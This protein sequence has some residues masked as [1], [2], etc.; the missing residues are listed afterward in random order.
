MLTDEIDIYI[1]FGC[2][3]KR[4]AALLIQPPDSVGN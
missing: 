4:L 1:F 3:N 2:E